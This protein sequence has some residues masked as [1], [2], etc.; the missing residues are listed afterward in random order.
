VPIRRP[1][2]LEQN[3]HGVFVLRLVIPLAHRAADGKP[4]EMRISLRTRD[5]AQARA[6][7]LSLNAQIEQLKL[8]RPEIDPRL[9]L[10]EHQ[11]R[12]D[13]SPGIDALHATAGWQRG[14]FG[15]ENSSPGA[16]PTSAKPFADVGTPSFANPPAPVRSGSKAALMLTTPAADA[17]QNAEVTSISIA[18]AAER[19]VGSRTSLANNR[20]NTGIEKKTSLSLLERFLRK[21]GID[22]EKAPVTKLSRALILE[23]VEAYARREGKTA[24]QPL[25]ARTVVKL[26]GHLREFF[27]FATAREWIGT[28]PMDAVFDRGVQGLKARAGQLKGRRN[29]RPFSDDDLQRIFDPESYLRFNSAA[30]EFWLPL[31]G[32]FTGARLGELVTLRSF[33]IRRNSVAGVWVMDLSG[34]NENSHRQVPLPQALIDLGFLNYVYATRRKLDQP[35]FPHR[36]MNPTRTADPSKHAS[37]AFGEYLT[38]VGLTD[39]LHVFHSFRHTVIS[40]MHVCGVPVGDAELIVGHAAQD[41]SIRADVARSHASRSGVHLGT[42]SHPGVYTIDTEPVLARLKRRLDASLTFQLDIKALRK[43]AAIVLEHTRWVEAPRFTSG[44]ASHWVSGWHTNARARA[45]REVSRL[46]EAWEPPDVLDAPE[47]VERYADAIER[48]ITKPA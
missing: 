44:L 47:E 38:K 32:L 40:R 23:F 34:K 16:E 17:P 8:R 11:T 7:S 27:D 3:R 14:T 35:L 26:I 9:V 22:P 24:A 29:Y 2:R 12:S 45:Q 42:Y 10:L 6:L 19:F 31:V 15:V 48:F 25:S 30:D 21:R 41:A 28:S 33:D 36:P 37:R 20:R 4:R 39:P 43:A 1:A 13:A 46:A 18:S 5:P